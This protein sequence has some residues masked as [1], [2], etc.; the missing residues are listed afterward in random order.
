MDALKGYFNT[1][2]NAAQS[3][4]ADVTNA[5]QAVGENAAILTEAET[6]RKTNEENVNTIAE[7]AIRLIAL[8]IVSM[9]ATACSKGFSRGFTPWRLVNIYACVELS[10]CVS[11]IQKFYNSPEAAPRYVSIENRTNSPSLKALYDASMQKL[12]QNIV[13]TSITA[14]L[15]TRIL[16]P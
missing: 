7:L 13:D 10:R 14:N 2:R 11:K 15:Y 9:L 4:I 12:K 3:T 6:A 5:A 1:A 8:G 16:R